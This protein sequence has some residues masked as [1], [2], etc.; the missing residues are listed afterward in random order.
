MKYLLSMNSIKY[1]QKEK[2]NIWIRLK[3]NEEI[4][5]RKLLTIS[6]EY[7]IGVMHRQS[8]DALGVLS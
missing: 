8:L 2:N 1:I 6:P 3:I 4:Y 5:S 7:S